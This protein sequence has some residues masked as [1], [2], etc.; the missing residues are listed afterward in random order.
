[1]NIF[2]R[3]YPVLTFLTLASI[4]AS[5]ALGKTFVREI[6]KTLP[7]SSGQ[8]LEVQ[9]GAGSIEVSPGK[10]DEVDVKVLLTVKASNEKEAEKIF[11]AT[12][13]SIEAKKDT[14][15]VQQK[16]R[17]VL[18]LFPRF[19]E[20]V[21]RT[22]IV[23]LC[24]KAFNLNLNTGSGSI[25][26][27]GITGT[28]AFQTGSGTIAASELQGDLDVRT[29]SGSINLARV[30]G[31]LEAKTGSGS[32]R[33]QELTGTRVAKTGSG[34]IQASGA[35]PHFEAKTGSGSVSLSS[36]VQLER[37]SSAT[38]GSG[39]V[40]VTLPAHTAL[41]LKAS[42]G[43]GSVQCAF[44][45]TTVFESSRKALVA[46][47]NDGGPELNLTAGSGNVRLSSAP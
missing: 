25:K 1:M 12:E 26:A 16:R 38:T 18:G 28:H 42:A 22:E 46:D 40:Q 5:P 33:V 39:S 14:V 19:S 37:H 6:T 41:H 10:P 29:G 4:I 11:A 3:I 30:N 24:P 15:L 43:S 20:N 13:V 21:P 32:L 17:K 35:I 34:E 7:V 36:S 9:A 31:S 23:V 47:L 45:A 44:P 8:T 27:S 2:K